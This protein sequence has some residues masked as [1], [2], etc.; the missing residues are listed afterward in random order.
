MRDDPLGTYAPPECVSLLSLAGRVKTPVRVLLK[1]WR[2]RG[3]EVWEID[4][5][6]R[7]RPEDIPKVIVRHVPLPEE[8]HERRRQQIV[9]RAE[10]AA[11]L[12]PRSAQQRRRRGSSASSARS[13]RD[14]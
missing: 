5:R 10:A 2:D 14:P 13:R 12:P 4:G 1:A 8:A 9:E 11:G 6:Y 7:V 3:L